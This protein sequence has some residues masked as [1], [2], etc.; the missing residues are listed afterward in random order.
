MNKTI[1]PAFRAQVGDWDYFLCLMKYAEVDRAIR[2]AYELGNNQDL[3]TMIQRGIT[4]R[5]GEIRDY[6]L[7]NKH[8]FLGSLVVASVGGNPTYTPVEMVDA[9]GLLTDVDREFGVLTFDGSH[10]FFAL[11]GQHRLKAI[12]DAIT[13]DQGLRNDDIGVIIV[14]HYN[15]EQGRQRTRRLFTNI[16]RNARATSAQENIAL[17]EDDGFAILTRRVIEEHP[18]LSRSG[19]VQVFTKQGTAGEI[20]LAG[21]SINV[22]SPAW[23]TIGVLYDVL[24]QLGHDLDASMMDRD[25][26]ATDQVLDDS[27]AVLTKRIDELMKASGDVRARMN[28]A[29]S[30]RDVR[31]PKGK[32]AEG[33]PFMRPVVQVAVAR[34]VRHLVLEQKDLTWD[35]ALKRLSALDWRMGAPPW[36][37]VFAED[38]TKPG[39]GKMAAGKGFSELLDALLLVH[40]AP[41]SK[42]QIQRALREYRSLKGK[43]YPVTE[44][45]L[46][47]RLPAPAAAHA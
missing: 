4:A 30:T 27:Y 20:T 9:E 10:M 36:S 8:H 47:A 14:P 34:A 22:T 5:T 29:T 32:E 15:D 45:Q 35:E 44:D 42:A 41:G 31:S 38:A 26:R 18:Y 37:A 24:K 21:R 39:A 46:A 28:A 12:K 1:I 43:R 2:F 6:L 33:H 25:H 23:T 17:D 13:Q 7:K 16:N 11:D 19:V 3:G 40:V